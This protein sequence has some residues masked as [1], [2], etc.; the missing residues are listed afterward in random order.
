MDDDIGFRWLIYW[1]FS[2]TMSENGGGK[3]IQIVVAD[4]NETMRLGMRVLFE[5][6]DSEYVVTEASD[7][8]G[9]LNELANYNYDLVIVEPLMCPGDG[10]TLI[11]QIKREAPDTPVLVY[12]DLDELKHGVRAIRTGARGYLMKSRPALELLAAANRV[13]SGR[14]HMSEF[15]A[16]EVALNAWGVRPESPHE[17]LT[18]REKMV[19]AMLVCGMTV[20]AIAAALNLSCKTVSTH[21]ARTLV[22]MRC[23]NL[24]ELV[25]YAFKRG[26]KE[27][28]EALCKVW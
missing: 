23:K 17:E 6:E 16:E 14:M 4:S 27:D 11:R 21:K 26:L 13:A 22:K 1:V 10:E 5:R 7:R 2:Y 25:E 15:L 8:C 28:C 20:T 18:E 3:M 24:S 19:F 9:L 12:T